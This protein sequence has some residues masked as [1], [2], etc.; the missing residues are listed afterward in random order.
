MV[1]E[2]PFPRLTPASPA[3]QDE[4]STAILSR[5]EGFAPADDPVLGT[6]MLHPELTETYMPFSDY[7]KN[8]GHL[9]KRDRELVI[10]RTAWNCGADYQWVAHRRYAGQAGIDDDQIERVARGPTDPGWSAYESAL[11]RAVD[12]LCEDHRIKSATWEVLGR[13]LDPTSLIELLMLVGNYQM[14]ALVMNSI[15]IKPKERPPALP[16]HRFL[17]AETAEKQQEGQR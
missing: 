12:E 1:D 2:P 11:L 10:M 7:L 14:I 16:G 17:F 5:V 4:G 13:D 15:G 9:Q 3:G 6:L 8:R